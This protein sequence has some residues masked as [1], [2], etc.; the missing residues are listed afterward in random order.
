[1]GTNYYARTNA[2]RLC[3]ISKEEIHIGKSSVGWTFTFHAIDEIR[4][5][6]DWLN[7]LDDE[8]IKIFN[9]YDKEISLV[10]FKKLVES[11]KQEKN[12]HAKQYHKNSF[13]DNEGNSM[14]K[15]EFSW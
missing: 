13:L 12:N 14:S 6:K 5:Y 1:M 8:H 7:F 9:E 15:G 10:N 11:K 3:G 2:C 4:S